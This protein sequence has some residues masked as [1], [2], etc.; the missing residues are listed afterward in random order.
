MQAEQMRFPPGYGSPDVLLSWPDVSA[1]LEAASH[2][3][4]ST[5][6][7]DGRPH[8]VPLD[9]VWLDD[10][11]YF[12]GS[13]ETVKQRNLEANPQAVMTLEDAM[14][15]VIVEGRCERLFPTGELARRLAAASKSKY[16][17]GPPPTSYAES[18]VWRLRP[19]RVLAWT[20]LP[21]DATRFTFG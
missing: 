6:R 16:G 19:Q 1:R 11:W 15:A 7:P 2:Y 21:R 13:P 17:Y 20:Q 14:E 3:W 4:L 5:V 12:G 10:D 8:A 18:G 9:G